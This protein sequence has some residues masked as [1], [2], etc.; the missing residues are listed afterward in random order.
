MEAR[1]LPVPVAARTKITHDMIRSAAADIVKGVTVFRNGPDD[2]QT[3]RYECCCTGCRNVPFNNQSS[4]PIQLQESQISLSLSLLVLRLFATRCL[5]P[6]FGTKA[7]ALEDAS[8]SST[9]EAQT[10]ARE[11]VVRIIND[12]R[13][14]NM[15]ISFSSI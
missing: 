14:V 8:S 7:L 11:G 15:S 13:E 6:M 10:V 4:C 2:I 9:A 1:L 3:S 12:D 5:A